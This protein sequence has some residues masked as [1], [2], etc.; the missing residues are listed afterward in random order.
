M[1]S[2]NLIKH[3]FDFIIM[4]KKQEEMQ[5]MKLSNKSG[6][7]II[8]VKQRTEQVLR[9]KYFEDICYEWLEYKKEQIK[10]SSYYNYKFQI[11]KYLIPYFRQ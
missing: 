5:Q 7:I 1:F 4:S 8:K 6:K 2:Q 3:F 10:E 11:E 9:I